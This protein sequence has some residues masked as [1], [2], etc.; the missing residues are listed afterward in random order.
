MEVIQIPLNDLLKPIPN[1][2][3]RTFFIVNDRLDTEVLRKALDDLVRNH[4]RKLGAR[5][6]RGAKKGRLE[7]HLPKAFADDYVLFKWSSED[8][9][10]S[11]D[12]VVS[13]LKRPAATEGIAFLPPMQ[14]VDSHF[15]P[16]DW[17]FEQKDDPPN[18]PNLYVHVRTFTDATVITISWLHVFGDQLGLGNMVRAWLGVVEG[19]E[20][21]PLVGHDEQVLP[22]TKEVSDYPKEKLRRKGRMRVKRHLENFF[23]ILGFVPELVFQSKEDH[24]NVF[25][26]LSIIESL[27][28]RCSKELAK[29]YG[30]DPGLSNADIMT[31]I[32]TKVCPYRN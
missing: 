22:H 26:P 1:I 17:P 24:Y 12:K 15:R 28:E 25:F 14:D 20:P 10:R 21:P 8:N 5:V 11:I 32:L 18:S 2:R 13:S 4:W 29:K 30:A 31:G 6:V 19:K 3:T 23:V 27:R 16:A 9:D 7:Y